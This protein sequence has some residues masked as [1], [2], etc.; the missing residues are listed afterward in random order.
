VT[1][2]V[3]LVGGGLG[4]EAGLTVLVLAPELYLPL[5]QL[6]AQFHASADGLAVAERILAL[7][8]APAEVDT[9]GDA[10]AALRRTDRALRGSRR[11]LPVATGSCSTARPRASPGETVALVGESGAGKSTVA[12]LALGSPSRPPGA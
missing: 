1:V 7:S 3:R 4:L 5:R 2:G 8:E 10:P 11:S 12:S 6:G 9:R